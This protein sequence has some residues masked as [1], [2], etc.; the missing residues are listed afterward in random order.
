MSNKPRTWRAPRTI[1]VEVKGGRGGS[2]GGGS[3]DQWVV[4]EVGRGGGG[5][6]MN[7]GEA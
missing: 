5:G 6:N 7:G 1:C 4:V 3:F 2:G